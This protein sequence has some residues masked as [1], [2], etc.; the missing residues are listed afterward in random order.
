[1]LSAKKSEAA[2]KDFPVYNAL[3]AGNPMKSAQNYQ[4]ICL[5]DDHGRT[6]T[7]WL[8][9]G[10]T[11]LQATEQQAYLFKNPPPFYRII[12]RMVRANA[13]IADHTQNVIGRHRKL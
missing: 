12:H 11:G 3:D 13:L 6:F 2:L 10:R 9:T 5:T 1:M 7:L 8:R 4:T